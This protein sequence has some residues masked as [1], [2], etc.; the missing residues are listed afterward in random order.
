[1]LV[2]FQS[3]NAELMLSLSSPDDLANLTVGQDITV[4]VTLSGLMA[5][6][7]LESLGA[8]IPIDDAVFS[9]PNAPSAGPIVPDAA[10][11]FDVF[12]S[13]DSDLVTGAFFL[14]VGTTGI[15][16][17][18]LF[19]SFT[20]MI[21]ASGSGEIALDGDSTFAE[22]V[23]GQAASVTTGGPLA[24]T[25]II[26]EPATLAIFGVAGLTLLKPHRRRPVTAT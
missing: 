2:A 8:D 16:T 12:S 23:G 10:A 15:V 9:T 19:Y 14:D 1:M 26:P 6:E 18:G 4:N 21:D 13:A 24:Y 3:A 5:S 20:M 22:L 25:V 17:N 7:E 11:N